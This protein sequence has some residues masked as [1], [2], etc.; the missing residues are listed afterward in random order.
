MTSEAEVTLLPPCPF[1]RNGVTAAAPL[2]SLTAVTLRPASAS[3]SM[4]KRILLTSLTRETGSCASEPEGVY[5]S[6][7]H[8]IGTPR[9]LS[10]PT[11]PEE[12]RLIL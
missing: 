2:Q 7:L 9:P 3:V 12:P 6:L 4:R 5:P 11:K 8:T 1:I 10:V